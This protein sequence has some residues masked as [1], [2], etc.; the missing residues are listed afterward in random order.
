MG[1]TGHGTN[2]PR[3]CPPDP[4]GTG[5]RP[6]LH[7]GR[8]CAWPGMGGG[9][10]PVP[11]SA[12]GA[13]EGAGPGQADRAGP[14]ASGPRAGRPPPS[15]APAPRSPGRVCLRGAPAEPTAALRVAHRSC[16]RAPRVYRTE[17][18]ANKHSGKESAPPQGGTQRGLPG[19]LGTRSGG[20]G[21]MGRK[22][23]GGRG[24]AGEGGRRHTRGVGTACGCVRVSTVV[25][26]PERP[27]HERPRGTEPPPASG[28]TLQKPRGVGGCMSERET[29][30]GATWRPAEGGKGARGP[31]AVARRLWRRPGPGAAGCTR[32]FRGAAFLRSHFAQNHN[33]SDTGVGCSGG[34]GGRRLSGAQLHPSR[35]PSPAIAPAHSCPEPPPGVPGGC[36][37]PHMSPR[38]PSRALPVLRAPV[39]R[40]TPPN[41]LPAHQP[42]GHGKCSW[43]S[44]AP[45]T[46]ASGRPSFRRGGQSI[47]SPNR[48]LR[49][50]ALQ[51]AVST[52]QRCARKRPVPGVQQR[53]LEQHR[54]QRLGSGG[55]P[56]QNSVHPEPEGF[57]SQQPSLCT[58]FLP[59]IPARQELAC[60]SRAGSASPP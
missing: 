58:P 43:S 49:G 52:D 31:R 22:R 34:G 9:A 53:A 27:E 54:G 40:T 10:R 17:G 35:R 46:A 60:P 14:Q 33:V 18:K 5:C 7:L 20:G 16:G 30:H 39:P 38:G 47:L 26:G 44:D 41:E 13:P 48:R 4:G 50:A 23:R 51:A 3:N 37:V 32:V 29:S 15:S 55:P 8:P 42:G 45:G 24:E 21:G 2:R 36:P 1:P 25:P 59:L 12:S 6:K 28:W 57:P 19:S 56:P 11:T